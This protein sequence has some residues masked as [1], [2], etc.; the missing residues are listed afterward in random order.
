MKLEDGK[1]DSKDQPTGM[2]RK[3]VN[4]IGNQVSMI[5]HE[6]KLQ[7]AEKE[8][9]SCKKS[10]ES[11][12]GFFVILAGFG[13]S[14][15]LL[16]FMSGGFGLFIDCENV[17]KHQRIHHTPLKVETFDNR[18]EMDEFLDYDN[19]TVNSIIFHYSDHL[20]TF[21]SLHEMMHS[22]KCNKKPRSITLNYYDNRDM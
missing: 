10:N 19:R 14:I 13:M 21:N 1:Q 18:Y 11:T 8:K 15:F 17:E 2:F 9:Q 16:C 5:K 22:S 7:K 3:F 12:E 4:L 20:E 6:W